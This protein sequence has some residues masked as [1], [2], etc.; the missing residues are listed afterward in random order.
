M[1]TVQT[2]HVTFSRAMVHWCRTTGRVRIKIL[3]RYERFRQPEDCL[4]KAVFQHASGNRWRTS[5]YPANK[6]GNRRTFNMQ[7]TG[8]RKREPKIRIQHA[9]GNRGNVWAHR[10]RSQKTEFANVQ[11]PIQQ[12]VEKGHPKIILNLQKKLGITEESSKFGIEPMKT[13]K[14]MWR[15]FMSPSMT[16]AI[17]PGPNYTENLAVYK[18][19]LRDWCWIDHSE[20]L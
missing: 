14:L 5:E 2:P 3:A 4:H 9:H 13:K 20:E 15:L 10:R 12:H 11:N 19:S 6:R 18:V 16:A 8:S 1:Q 7:I 17:H